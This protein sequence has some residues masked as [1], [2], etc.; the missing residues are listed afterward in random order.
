MG[1][2]TNRYPIELFLRYKELNRHQVVEFDKYIRKEQRKGKRLYESSILKKPDTKMKMNYLIN[3]KKLFEGNEEVTDNI[4][5]L[6]N[7]FCE[8]NFTELLAG[9][10]N[11]NYTKIEHFQKLSECIIGK[12]I[13]ETQYS[14]IYADLCSELLPYYINVTEDVDKSGTIY[15][16]R[17]LLNQ[18]QQMFD[19]Y[20]KKE[21]SV[22]KSRETAVGFAKF[23]GELYKK[24]LLPS[25]IVSKLAEMLTS[26]I[27]SQVP[28]AGDAICSLVNT[29]V[30]IVK[31]KD[32]KLYSLM[33]EK[34][35]NL[36]NHKKLTMR[37]KFIVQDII[38]KI[39][40][41]EK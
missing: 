27:D 8:K 20:V 4:Q 36:I 34:I 11:I 18:C 16:R 22:V 38:E 12:A 37:E 3:K 30:E 31:T 19:K 6:V 39:E 29:I 7:K 5:N 17:I 25:V 40:S 24:E 32:N 1:E 28:Y 15:F 13:N 10:K 9:I 33:K 14:H 26:G 21:E 35:E 2:E 23:L 41:L